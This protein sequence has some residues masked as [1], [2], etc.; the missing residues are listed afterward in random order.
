M[1]LVARWIAVVVLVSGCASYETVSTQ[2]VEKGADAADEVLEAAEWG[3]TQA[4]TI[5]AARRR[6]GVDGCCQLCKARRPPVIP[7]SQ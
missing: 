3:L 1:G 2:V 6:Y 7:E 4:A 5:G